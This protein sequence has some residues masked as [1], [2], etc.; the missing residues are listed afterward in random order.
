MI[1]AGQRSR[2][3]EMRKLE[4]YLVSRRSFRGPV[5]LYSGRKIPLTQLGP[6]TALD[7]ASERGLGQRCPRRVGCVAL[8]SRR[9]DGTVLDVCNQSH[10]RVGVDPQ[11]QARVTKIG[12]GLEADTV[13]LGKEQVSDV[14]DSSPSVV[15]DT[16]FGELLLLADHAQAEGHQ[17]DGRKQQ[18]TRN[19]KTCRQCGSEAMID[20]L[21]RAPFYDR[22]H[23][24]GCHEN[25][26]EGQRKVPSC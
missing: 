8:V 26:M 15:R 12:E 10:R 17:H 1:R 14:G 21:R 18:A 25:V 9:D 19:K 7:L 23:P 2:E 4:L 5:G 22:F 16:L 20:A 11:V 24:D 3:H 6:P 13:Q